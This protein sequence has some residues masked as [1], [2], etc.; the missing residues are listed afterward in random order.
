M[1]CNIA[2]GHDKAN[3]ETRVTVRPLLADASSPD[4]LFAV[5]N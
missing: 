2:D 3:R 1:G 4:R 5:P